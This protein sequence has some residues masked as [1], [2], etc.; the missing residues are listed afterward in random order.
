MLELVKRQVAWDPKS[1]ESRLNF[2][3]EVGDRLPSGRPTAFFNTWPRIAREYWE[4]YSDR[5]QR[6]V[7]PTE[8]EVSEMLET[9]RLLKLLDETE[10]HIVLLTL[11]K[12][13]KRVAEEKLGMHRTTLYRQYQKVLAKLANLLNAADIQRKLQHTTINIHKVSANRHEC[14]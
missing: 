7:E 9:M 4:E 13:P 6:T 5:I 12:I 1:V 8:D 2:A 10:R 14:A 11:L 3:I